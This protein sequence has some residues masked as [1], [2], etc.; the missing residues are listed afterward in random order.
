MIKIDIPIKTV[1]ESNSSEHWS[2]KAKRHRQ[3]QFFVRLAMNEHLSEV[4]LPCE[5]KLI[6]LA[7]R[8]L[9][10]DNLRG[11]LK[12][13]RDEISEC[14]IPEKAG[15]YI[16]RSGTV[17]RIKGRADSDPRL[18]WAYGQEKTKTQGVRIMITF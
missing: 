3:Q 17:R 7:P 16:T 1:S 5:I 12:Y 15:T 4:K 8:L 9:D 6:R 10:D 18:T 14:L 11:C 13:V 2:K